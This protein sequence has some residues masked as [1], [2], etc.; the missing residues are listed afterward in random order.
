[1]DKNRIVQITDTK[2]ADIFAAIYNSANEL[3]AAAEQSAAGADIFVPQIASDM[4][5]MKIQENG[6]FSAFMSYHR[7]GN[8]YELT[9]LYVKKE[10]QQ[11]GIGFQLLSHMEALLR[12]NDVI[13][14]SVLKNAPWAQNFY[15]KHGFHPLNSP[16]RPADNTKYLSP[17]FSCHK[18]REA[19]ASLNIVEKS[20]STVFYKISS[21]AKR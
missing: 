4:N 16:H 3:F 5:F 6:D 14:V 13:F 15:G 17:D 10:Y 7:Y 20:Y 11:N 19:A 8:F 12:N 9:S 1:M 2:Y 21:S 18:L